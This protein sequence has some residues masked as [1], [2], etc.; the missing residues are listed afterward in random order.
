MVL[1]GR[2]EEP[3]RTLV[4]S[5]LKLDLP[6]V[7]L[8]G[9]LGVLSS[10]IASR[11]P[12]SVPYVVVEA[13]PDII[14]ICRRNATANGSRTNVRVRNKALA[15]D[16]EAVSFHASR[17]IHVS[18]VASHDRPGN[19]TVPAA[20]LKSML[21]EEGIEGA[22]SLVCDI[23]GME[24]DLHLR[25]EEALMKCDVAIIELHPN[26]FERQARRVED[27]IERL[28]FLGLQEIARIANVYAFR[29]S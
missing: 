14:E 26:Q 18:S 15:Y 29:R 27:F 20:S 4:E 6:V 5:F 13:N 9:S 8:G 25:D 12:E 22:Y 17:N 21:V 1:T 3:E 7:E 24:W 28:K 2:Y 11:L 16:G 10:F 23:E 19:V